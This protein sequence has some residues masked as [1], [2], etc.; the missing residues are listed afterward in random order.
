MDN[1][2][3]SQSTKKY[4]ALQIIS[5]LCLFA[6]LTLSCNDSQISEG[7]ISQ[8]E[9]DV[10]FG[11]DMSNESVISADG[12][13]V[14]FQSKATNLIP[15]DTNG[16]VDIFLKD[17]TNGTI[18]LVS[19]GANSEQGDQNSYHPSISGDGRFVTFSSEATNLGSL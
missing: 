8:N 6:V 16:V 7:E 4:P 19:A 15:D 12:R 13:F 17:L 1:L 11:N 5:C 3:K 9:S 2:L 18:R 10:Q 14:T